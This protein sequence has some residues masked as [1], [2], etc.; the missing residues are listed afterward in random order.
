MHGLP[1]QSPLE[2]SQP[3]NDEEKRC[4]AWKHKG[5]ASYAEWL[6]SSNDF[7][8]LRRFGALNVRVMLF[9]QYRITCLEERLKDIDQ[10]VAASPNQDA[11]NDSLRWDQGSVREE[12]L[13]QLI[14]LLREYSMRNLRPW[15]VPQGSC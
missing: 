2:W 12:I 11:R 5:Y 3:L 9:M 6:A 13:E 7:L 10:R 14:P 1:S 8:V 4:A 15:S